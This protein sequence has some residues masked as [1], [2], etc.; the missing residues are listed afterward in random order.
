MCHEGNIP[1]NIDEIH[2]YLKKI[3]GWEVLE[4]KI[5]GFHL[6]KNFKFKNFLQSQN[7][8]IKLRNS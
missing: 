5:D 2:T 3:D 7:S 8:L 6:I 4:D 1:F